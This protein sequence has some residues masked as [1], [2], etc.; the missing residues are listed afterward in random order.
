MQ[1]R[2]RC[3]WRHCLGVPCPVCCWRHVT[4]AV[5]LDINSGG[6]G[7]NDSRKHLSRPGQI[8]VIGFLLRVIGTRNKVPAYLAKVPASFNP[9]LSLGI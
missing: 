4:G 6:G 5:A 8:L 7:D 1:V 3:V 9:L 2:V